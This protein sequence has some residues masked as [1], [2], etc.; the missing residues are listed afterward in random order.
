MSEFVELNLSQDNGGVHF[1]SG[2]INQ[3]F[4][5][6]AEGMDGAIGLRDAER[7]DYRAV[8]TALQKQSQFIDMRLGCVAVADE[9]VGRDSTQARKTREAF[10]RIEV[11]DAPD[12]PDPTP[13]PP[14][15]APDSVLFLRDASGF[16]NVVLGCRETALSD[17]PL[18]T[19][20][21]LGTFVMPRRISVSGDGSLAVFVTADNDLGFLSTDGSGVSVAD[22]AGAIHAVAIAPNASR[23]AVVFRDPV[24]GLPE[25]EIVI[26]DLSDASEESIELV[27]PVADG[28]AQDIVLC[29][30]AMEFFPD[31]NALLCDAVSEIPLRVAGVFKAGHASRWTW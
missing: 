2:I 20:L 13:I 23:F 12:T 29:A 18:G 31:G 19:V 26:I 24:S 30:D 7:I 11:F 22:R 3:G 15:N 9:L 21:N 10:D 1:N 4:Y 25:N 28:T 17:G 5:L 14:I 8:T 27:A 6:L 16:G